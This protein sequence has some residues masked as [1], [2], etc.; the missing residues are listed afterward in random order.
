MNLYILS[1][2]DEEQAN[3]QIEILEDT[4]EKEGLQMS[5]EKNEIVHYW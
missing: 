4:V 3:I 5:V 1:V 2:K